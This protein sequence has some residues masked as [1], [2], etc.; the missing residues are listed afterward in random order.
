MKDLSEYH[1]QRSNK[2]GLN[3]QCKTCRAVQSEVYYSNNID[4]FKS[5]KKEWL[6]SDKGKEVE[7]S[8][9]KKKSE[10]NLHSVKQAVRNAVRLGSLIKPKICSLCGE[11]NKMIQAHHWSYKREYWLDVV[12]CCTQCHSDIHKDKPQNITRRNVLNLIN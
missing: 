4:Y 2:S 12:W 8:Y 7:R 6:A 10:L 3:P 9:H 5:K 11:S 1:V